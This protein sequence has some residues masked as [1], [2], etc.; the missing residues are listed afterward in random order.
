VGVSATGLIPSA[1][2]RLGTGPDHQG[3]PSATVQNA[4]FSRDR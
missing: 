4:T 1:P 2:F 3:D